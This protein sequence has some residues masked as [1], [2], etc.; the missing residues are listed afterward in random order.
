MHPPHHQSSLPV[1]KRLLRENALSY[2]KSYAIAFFFMAVVAAT[3]ALSAWIMKDIINEIFINRELAMV[4][5]ISGA[6]IFIY[7]VKGLSLYVSNITLNRIGNNIVAKMQARMFDSILSQGIR[8][9]QSTTVGD[10]ATRI[11]NNAQAARSAI[12]QVV[13]SLG[14]D[15]LTLIGLCTV[16]IVQ[17][18]ILSL[19]ALV[20]MPIAVIGVASLVRKVRLAARREVKSIAQIITFV[21]E[22]AVGIRVVKAFGLEERL[23]AAMGAAIADV[24]GQA[25]RI[26]NI[27]AR[28]SPLMETL[29]GFAIALVILFGGRQVISD[30]HDPGAFF[31]FITAV[32]LAYE[33]AKRLARLQVSLQA[34]LV[35]VRMMYDLVDH[36]PDMKEVPDARPLVVGRGEVA[37]E[38]VEFSYGKLPTLRTLTLTA[39]AGETTALVGPSGAGKTTILALILRF[40]D[41]AAGKVLIDG[42]DI[43]TATLA[44]LRSAMALVAQDTF[45]FAGTVASNIADGRPAATRAEIEQAARDAHADEFIRA[46]PNGYDTPVTEGGHTFSGGQRQRIAIARAMLRNA[47]ILLL[48][49]ATSALDTAS[50]VKVQDALARLMKGRTTIVIAHRL[51]TVRNADQIHVLE[52]G[53]VVESGSHE[54][55]LAKGGAYAHLHATQFRQTKG[56]QKAAAS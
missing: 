17:S 28:T 15:F 56:E 53:N 27:A 20:V 1:I 10:L 43:R 6:V 21:Q 54:M 32:L 31:S 55:L 49:E 38:N 29:G 26:A 40:F 50:E 51:S 44:S 18:P 8:F 36:Q 7:T 37:F 9:F 5:T 33:P 4:Y 24:E 23:R 39:R 35:G 14:R 2:W 42:V 34:D 12:D 41:P 16:M 22:T 45:L 48:D 47:P 46:L 19:V 11:T 30:G 3:T 13:V 25:N 52:N